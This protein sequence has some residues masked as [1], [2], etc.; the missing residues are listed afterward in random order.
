MPGEGFQGHVTAE[1]SLLGVSGRWSVVQVD[2]D[3][4]MESMYR[5]YGTLDAELEVR[6]TIRRAE[7]ATS[8]CLLREA[9]GPTLVHVDNKGII[10]GIGQ[11]AKDAHL[12]ITILGRGAK[13][14]Q[15]GILVEFEHVNAHRSNKEMQ[16]SSSLKATRKQMS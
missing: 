4:E 5:L 10:G 16:Q 13:S 14:H 2:H 8:L 1:G 15:E 6:R 3:E 12:W 11:K 7:L 9:V